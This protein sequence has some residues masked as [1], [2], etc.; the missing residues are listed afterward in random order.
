MAGHPSPHSD[1]KNPV[2][3]RGSI[4]FIYVYDVS[5]SELEALEKGL[6]S[7]HELGFG[8]GL[9]STAVA[10]MIALGTTDFKWEI[11]KQICIILMVTGYVFGAYFMVIWRRTRKSVEEVVQRIKDRVDTPP[12]EPRE[13]PEIQAFRRHIQ[14]RLALNERKSE[15]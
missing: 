7:N 10:C 14:A 4:D 8:I 5:E 13:P 1:I 3:R 11:V 15:E 12:D 9:L 6:A 2:I